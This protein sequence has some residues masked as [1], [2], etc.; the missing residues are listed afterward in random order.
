MITSVS[1]PD[2]P[3]IVWVTAVAPNSW[4]SLVLE[5]GFNQVAV[6]RGI[7][8]SLETGLEGATT[9]LQ[10][11]VFVAGTDI[12][13]GSILVAD[14]NDPANPGTGP[15]LDITL[16]TIPE[17]L[18]P[19]GSPT[20]S[21]L[22]PGSGTD[23]ILLRIEPLE[24]TPLTMTTSWESDSGLVSVT[25]IRVGDGGPGI[26]SL[27]E[28][29]VVEIGWGDVTDPNVP[30]AIVTNNSDTNKSETGQIKTG[31]SAPAPLTLG[32]DFNCGN[33]V[34]FRAI[35]GD[36]QAAELQLSTEVGGAEFAELPDGGLDL[37]GNIRKLIN[38]EGFAGRLSNDA[39]LLPAPNKF[40]EGSK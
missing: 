18:D 7:P 37:F 29:P 26:A 1:Y 3:P 33:I 38:Q 17:K 8:V 6:L 28:C 40:E 5:C 36:S 30:G 4:D 2:Q 12:D 35:A 27:I 16:Q 25:G 32:N 10:D 23:L 13:C 9:D 20:Q 22:A 21:A 34:T 14:I 11:P 15:S 39:A 19:D 24:G 31:L